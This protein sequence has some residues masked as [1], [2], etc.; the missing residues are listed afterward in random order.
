MKI[1]LTEKPSIE[2]KN[3][4]AVVIFPS[5]PYWFSATQ[6]IKTVL[7]ILEFEIDKKNAVKR[8]ASNLRIEKS[9]AEETIEEIKDLLYPNG[10]LAINGKTSKN[11]VNI[12]PKYQ[13]NNVE[14][15]LVIGA[16]QNCNLFCNHC[17]ANARRPLKNEITMDDFKKIINDLSSMPWDSNISQVGLTGGEFF[18]RPDAL[19]IIDYIHAAGF[20]ILVS[21]NGL[22][23]ND[24][25]ISKISSYSKLNISISIDG[26]NAK[27]HE[28]IR[29]KDT[30]EKTVDVVKKLT[31]KG[32]SVGVNMFIHQKNIDLIE[33]T[34][35]LS[36]KLGV[37]AFNCLSLMHVG[38]ANSSKSKKEII[39]IPEKILY[40]KLF[41]ILDQN[42]QYQQL[43]INSTFANQIMGI[44]G[45]VKSHYCGIGTNRALYIM[46]DGNVYP[47]P[48]T[49][50][51]NFCLGNI[52]KQK[53]SDIWTNSIL[54]KELRKLDVDT[55]NST[56]S[57]CDVRYYC[58]GGCRG[59]N[60]QVTKK[61][62]SP[63]FNCKENREA[64]LEM[65]WILT[66]NPDFF[67]EKVEELYQVIN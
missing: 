29:G 28:F 15:V 34:L 53:L 30:F 67:Q 48:D 49:A 11:V 22:L 6:E 55:M 54:L 43:M 63:H 20:E 25:M 2:T 41:Q 37:N 64:I 18:I 31:D 5:R 66:E 9:E 57:S 38:R 17:Y 47:C 50:I 10:V 33:D 26:P 14:A 3:G 24:E 16:T 56:C 35:A 45:G 52:K 1:Q 12:K 62:K 27:T 19:K 65:M 60:Y 42:K 61:L 8:V 23:L 58:A 4:K 21:S 36:E 13:I 7:G 46:A 32:V 59:E 44:S 39:R 40:R 51:K